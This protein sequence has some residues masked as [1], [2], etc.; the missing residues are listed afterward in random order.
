MPSAAGT[1][2]D[3]DTAG[4]TSRT[5]RVKRV[6]RRLFFTSLCIA[7]TWILTHVLDLVLWLAYLRGFRHPSPLVGT[8]RIILLHMTGAEV[9]Q[10]IAPPTADA[11]S[12]D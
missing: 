11:A 6:A 1:D 12:S 2:D 10:G 7:A 9:R 4:A 3:S 8:V 5:R